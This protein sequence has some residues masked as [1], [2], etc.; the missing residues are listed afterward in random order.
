M[1]CYLTSI[2]KDR[3]SESTI[4][5]LY[6]NREHFC[7]VLEDFDRDANRDGDLDDDGE[8]KIYGETAIPSGTYPVVLS[9][10]NKFKRI[11]PEI[12]NVKGFSGIRIHRG[13]KAKDSLGCLIVGYNKGINTVFDSKRCE[14]DLIAE[15]KKYDKIYIEIK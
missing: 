13:N 9:Y 8:A 4:S 15:L 14:E 11:L 6:L 7:Y 12:L 10:S 2:R 5:D 3:T 1:I